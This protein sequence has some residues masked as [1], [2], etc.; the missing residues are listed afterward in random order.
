M[1]VAVTLVSAPRCLSGQHQDIFLFGLTVDGL[2]VT[3]E[4]ILKQEATVGVPVRM[5]T[6]YLQWPSQPEQGIFPASSLEAIHHLG[7]VPCVTWEPMY[8]EHQDEHMIPA[9]S[10]L[11]GDYNPYIISFA[12]KAAAWGHPFILRLAHEMNIKRYHWGTSAEDYGPQSPGLYRKMFR[13]I[14]SVF[15]DQ[16]ADNVLF[17]FC[18]NAESVPNTSYDPTA[19]WNTISAYYPGDAYVHILGLDGYNWGTTQ[20]REHHGWTSTWQSFADI[21][22]NGVHR[23]RMLND[24]KPLIIFET[25]SAQQGGDRDEWLV[26]GLKA[27]HDWNIE[28]LSWFQVDK[29][30]DWKVTWKDLPTAGPRLRQM[31]SPVGEWISGLGGD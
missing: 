30:V 4:D 18:P 27:V 17:T 7:A 29:E 11:Q 15:Q 2:P 26:H 5:V 31:T 24:H 3:T 8:Y 10:I 22:A 14:V 6:F 19:G 20:T 23:L 9:R 16:G 12:Q 13:H 25:G 28:G 21:F 1:L